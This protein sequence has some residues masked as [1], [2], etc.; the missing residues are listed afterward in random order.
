MSTMKEPAYDIHDGKLVVGFFIAFLRR[1][2]YDPNAVVGRYLVAV[3][4]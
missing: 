2:A 1:S 4:Y 3:P